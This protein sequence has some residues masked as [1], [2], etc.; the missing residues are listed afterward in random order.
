MILHFNNQFL[1]DISFFESFELGIC[2][3]FSLFHKL[4]NNVLDGYYQFP[5]L[6]VS[7]YQRG[8]GTLSIS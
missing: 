7:S 3:L 8:S 2:L 5:Y 6:P 4:S 1:C